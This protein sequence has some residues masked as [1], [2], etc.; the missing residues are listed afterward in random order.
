MRSA[1]LYRVHALSLEGNLIPYSLN[2]GAEPYDLG[3]QSIA[4]FTRSGQS[5]AKGC[6]VKVW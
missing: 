2:I 4:G 6:L 3:W 5:A 1:G